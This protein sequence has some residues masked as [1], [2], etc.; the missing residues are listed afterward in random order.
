MICDHWAMR[1]RVESMSG[2]KDGWG[3]LNLPTSA[4]AVN[5]REPPLGLLYKERRVQV[6]DSDTNIFRALEDTNLL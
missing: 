5:R 3:S 2:S 4:K 1:R 6:L